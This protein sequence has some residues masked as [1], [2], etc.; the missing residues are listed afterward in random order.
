MT[1]L[2]AVDGP[3]HAR[4][5]PTTSAEPPAPPQYRLGVAA[6]AAACW[7]PGQPGPAEPLLRQ[8]LRDS[9]ERGDRAGVYAALYSLACAAFEQDRIDDA[10]DLAE[11]A[12]AAVTG[13][14]NAAQ[15]RPVATVLAALIYRAADDP[16]RTCHLLDELDLPHLAAAAPLQAADAYRERGFASRE[17]ADPDAARSDWLWAAKLY[18]Q[19]GAHRAADHARTLADTY[20][21]AP[22]NT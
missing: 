2:H 10:V 19:I 22:A 15:E 13:L 20:T 17:R 8:A 14:D 7:S 5:P 21:A 9:T 12:L 4:R 1:H 3:P 18:R 11:Q 16:A 6:L